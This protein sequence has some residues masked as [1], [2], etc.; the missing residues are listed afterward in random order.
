[1]ASVAAASS[2]CAHQHRPVQHQDRRQHQHHQRR[3]RAQ[4]QRGQRTQADGR[5]LDAFSSQSPSAERTGPPPASTITPV[6][7][8]ASTAR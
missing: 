3:L 5:H 4:G 2:S 8:S 1:L 6:T 7:S